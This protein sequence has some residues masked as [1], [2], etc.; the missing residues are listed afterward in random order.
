MIDSTI[1][2]GPMANAV[3]EVGAIAETAKP[4]AAELAACKAK[5]ETNSFGIFGEER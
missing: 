4:N 3:S 5:V 2:Q 1:I